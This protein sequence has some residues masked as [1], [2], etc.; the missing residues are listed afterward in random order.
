VGG[1]VDPTGRVKGVRLSLP[2]REPV[3]VAPRG[4]GL[5]DNGKRNALELLGALAE[6]L[7]GSLGVEELLVRTKPSSSLPAS[8]A[9]LRELAS[10]CS[11][12]IAGVGD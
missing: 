4:L 12:V 9:I 6:E 7:R 1:L 5:L 3:G 10:R 11:I 2:R 8:E